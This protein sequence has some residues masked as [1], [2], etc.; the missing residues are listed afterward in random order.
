MNQNMLT[1]YK[2]IV[3]AV[4]TRVSR[5]VGIEMEGEYDGG[6]FSAIESVMP[7]GTVCKYDGSLDDDGM[8]V[9]SPIMND[10]SAL[11]DILKVMYDNGWDYTGKAGT[12]IH[13]DTSDYSDE[14]ILRLLWFGE[15]VQ[16]IMWSLIM[17]YRFGNSWC[18]KVEGFKGIPTANFARLDFPP[19][20]GVKWWERT[21]VSNLY[22][23]WWDVYYS[24]SNHKPSM[25][26][27]WLVPKEH[28][29][30]VEM[31]LFGWIEEA[32]EAI[33]YCHLAHNLVELVKASTF[34]HLQ[35]IL[36]NIFSAENAI[37]AAERFTEALGLPAF[38]MRGRD[39]ESKVNKKLSDLADERE[40]V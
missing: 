14:D 34:E 7:A 39:A 8:E 2:D 18:P 12:H 32:D 25:T 4:G 27:G 28:Y 29:K 30:T 10:L 21:R 24:Y 19:R 36:N 16:D 15:Q 20:A 3:A 35:F 13:V 40:A 26:V 23:R 31:R 22:K 38:P 33:A 9:N 5:T 17:D 37:Q 1:Q 6:S 11:Y